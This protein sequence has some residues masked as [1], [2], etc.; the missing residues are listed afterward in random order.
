MAEVTRV[1][2]GHVSDPSEANSMRLPGMN[3]IV[4]SCGAIAAER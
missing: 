1:L 4:A 2:P 3:T